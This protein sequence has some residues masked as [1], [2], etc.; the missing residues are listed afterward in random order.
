MRKKQVY[1]VLIGSWFLT[2]VGCLAVFF[3]TYHLMEHS[4]G[5]ECWVY[6]PFIAIFW[7]TVSVTLA[8]IWVLT[9]LSD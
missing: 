6:G 7:G 5:Y 9:Y 4:L 8:L 1:Q 3:Y 2:T